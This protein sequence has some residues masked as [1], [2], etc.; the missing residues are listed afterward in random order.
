MWEAETIALDRDMSREYG[1][2]AR[3]YGS[4]FSE[5]IRTA[6]SAIGRMFSG[7]DSEN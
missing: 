2:Y 5:S 3:V 4:S 6:W 1:T 7:D